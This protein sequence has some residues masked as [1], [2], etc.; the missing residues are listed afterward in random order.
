MSPIRRSSPTWRAS[1]AATADPNP[2]NNSAAAATTAHQPSLGPTDLV[3]AKSGTPDPVVAGQDLTYT[4]VVTNSGPA[5]ATNVQVVDALPSGV[6]FVGATASQGLC[7]GGITC[8]LGDLAVGATARITVVVTVASG[9]LT[10][11][12][13]VARVSAAN[14]DSNPANNQATTVTAVNQQADLGMRKTGPA[15]ATPGGGVTFQIVVTNAGP[16]DAQ[17]VVVSDTLAAALQSATA[18]ASQ[19]SCAVVAGLLTCNLGTVPAGGSATINV[20]ATIASG[21][22][23]SLNNTAAVTSA[24]PDPLPINNTSS[25]AVALSPAADL[26][27]TKQDAA[28]PVLAGTRLVYTLTVRN[29]GPAAASDVV[30]TDT[31]PYGVSFADSSQC[32]ETAPGSGIVT[33]AAA[34]NPLPAG[35]SAVFTLAVNVS[36]ALPTSFSLVNRAVVGSST[37]D[38]NPANNNAVADTEVLAVVALQI[39]KTSAPNPVVAGNRLTYT[40]VVTNSGP[41]ESTDTRVIDTLPFGT[42]LVS[43]TPSNAGI[44]NSG[45]LCLLGTLAVGEVVSVTIVV[46]VDPALRQG[47]VFTNTASAFCESDSAAGARRREQR[48]DR[49]GVGGHQR[50]E[51][52]SARSGGD[53]RQPALPVAGRQRRAFDGVQRARDRHAR[54]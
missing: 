47:T 22:I 23:G 26:A 52:R 38:P 14:P 53:R 16:S 49:G 31:L 54:H 28:D 51:A 30:V 7:S 42:H 13:N 43:A 48:D 1:A 18:A 20:N 41:A 35:A 39:A 9:Q 10:A 21:A 19:G 25:T 45:I 40:V 29:L 27:L 32:A 8:N 24:T 50:A 12:T 5:A 3:I 37:A 15:T 36:A 6:T 11:L 46:D 2:A 44:C 33:C 17:A 34:A 4:L